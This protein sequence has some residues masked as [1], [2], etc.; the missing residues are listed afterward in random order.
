[1]VVEAN[2][3]V[4]PFDLADPSH[5]S[6]KVFLPIVLPPSHEI[7]TQTAWVLPVRPVEIYFLP[8]YKT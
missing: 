7:I 8:H 1:M 3:N 2:P 6:N 5:V 4:E